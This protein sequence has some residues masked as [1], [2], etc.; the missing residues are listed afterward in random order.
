MIVFAYAYSATN[1]GNTQPSNNTVNNTFY[2]SIVVMGVVILGILKLNG[3]N[4]LPINVHNVRPPL[5]V[6]RISKNI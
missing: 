3:K 2:R 5:K 4:T 1:V 6:N